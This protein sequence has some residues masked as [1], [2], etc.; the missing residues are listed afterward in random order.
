MRLVRSL[1]VLALHASPLFAQVIKW[2]PSLEDALAQAKADNKPVLLAF[3]L[4]GERASEELLAD[5]YRDAAI[6]KLAERTL[7]VF[8]SIAESAQVPGVTPAQHQAAE[9]KA[10]TEI[11]AIGPGEDV[12][13][14]QHVF[15][16]SD[17]KVLVSAAY[18]M[19]KGELEWCFAE[20][21]R[22]LDPTFAWTPSLRARAPA[23]LEFG[24]PQS[25]EV[26]KPP[27]KAEVAEALKEIKKS[28]GGFGKTMEHARLLM[29]SD[30]PE[31]LKFGETT[32]RGLPGGTKG[33]ILRGI[34][35]ASP[36]AWYAVLVPY[37][38]SSDA[39][40]RRSTA[41]SLESLAEPKALPAL[42]K[43]W[44]IEK[45]ENVRG[46]LLRAMATCG[47]DQKTVA[48]AVQKTVQS[49]SET[50]RIHA[51]VALGSLDDGTLVRD[52]LRVVLTDAAPKV[53]STAAYVIATRREQKLLEDLDRV[54]KDEP[55]TE[56]KQWLTAA[57]E[58]LRG[59][60]G[61]AFAR[62]KTTVLGERA[63]T[64][65]LTGR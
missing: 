6:G 54:A 2:T 44:K 27:T 23:A 21:I 50:M 58:V 28:R 15:V 55:D 14:P 60:S 53:R 8:C 59:G 33:Q 46:R 12:I 32:L 62:F 52:V 34:G 36:R 19:S 39:E 17:G 61:A 43:Q 30:D 47:P 4:E 48:Q 20:A 7:N 5:H 24:K 40:L 1:A 45:D 11:L 41:I 51:T 9:K 10:R 16:D 31:A 3:N 38:E 35:A 26:T 42:Q 29:R 13:A 63:L 22:K 56:A 64:E 25:G 65:G 57:L 49:G 18:R 37:L